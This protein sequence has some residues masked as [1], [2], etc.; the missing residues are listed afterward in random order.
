MQPILLGMISAASSGAPD[1]D[2]LLCPA[3]V[4]YTR[5]AMEGTM[6]PYF[7]SVYGSMDALGDLVDYTMSGFDTD[8]GRCSHFWQNPQVVVIMPEPVDYFQ[9]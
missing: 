9:G 3:V 2:A 6:K 7:Q 4:A 1:A 8:A 5:K